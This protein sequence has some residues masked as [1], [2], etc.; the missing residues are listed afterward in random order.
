MQCCAL[1]QIH[2]TLKKKHEGVIDFFVFDWEGFEKHINID[3]HVL[4]LQI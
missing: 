2:S 4:H 1:H 3:K